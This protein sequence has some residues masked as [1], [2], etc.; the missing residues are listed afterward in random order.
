MSFT[1]TVSAIQYK[2]KE[3]QEN[4]IGRHEEIETPDDNKLDTAWQ[5]SVT[6]KMQYA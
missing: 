2:E 5:E 6:I 4:Q 1:N 3:S